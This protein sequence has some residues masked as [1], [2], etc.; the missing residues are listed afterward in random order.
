MARNSFTFID[1][2][3]G[4]GGFHA[5]LSQ[6]GGK[7]VLASDN[8]PHASVVYQRN[9]GTTPKG[10]IRTIYKRS[11]FPECAD[12]LVA[13]FPCQPF[14]K[15]GKQEGRSEDRGTLVDH[16]LRM[17][18]R[19]K[20]TVVI[21]ENVRNI[22][23]IKHR[24]TYTGIIR[25]LRRMGY[26]VSDEPGIFSPHRIRPEFGG[27]P[28]TRDRVFISATYWPE[29]SQLRP[30]S[31][32]LPPEVLID[33]P[34]EWNILDYLD[35]GIADKST[36]LLSSEVQVLE[37]WEVFRQDITK[38]TGAK[39]PGF[40][41][42]SDEWSNA[43][44][45]KYLVEL[46]SWKT[47]FIEKNWHFYDENEQTINA[48]LKEYGVRRWERTSFR[49]LEW[50]STERKSLWDCA[51]Q[52][53]PSGVRVKDATYLPALV[54]MSQTSII[55]PCRRRI[56]VREAARLQGFPED[57]EFADQL[58]SHSYKQI[59]NAVNVG[60][61]AQVLRAHVLRDAKRVREVSPGLW[62][63]T[64]RISPRSP[65]LAVL[66]SDGSSATASGPRRSGFRN[67]S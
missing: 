9:W 50:Q 24:E 10:D 6:I 20:P 17:I 21:L 57:F 35:Q 65:H 62:S 66:T 43:R 22:V 46:P 1:L 33:D 16:A 55:G 41:L 19:A 30:E 38:Q 28:Q 52:F 23:G 15:S 32:E 61:V 8:D 27:R 39:L 37:A 4:I 26:S 13:G 29:H 3:S 59:G 7:C 47:A 64:R 14:S 34:R 5:S 48:W 18:A 2:F 42:W 58:S 67:V 63:A 45:R 49:K 25:R 54:A 56:S 53:R 51:I 44:R 11:D 12:V 40:P 60:V 36:A 31:L